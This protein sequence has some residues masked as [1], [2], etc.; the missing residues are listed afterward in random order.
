MP[1]VVFATGLED[2]AAAGIED[3]DEILSASVDVVRLEV[4]VKIWATG[5]LSQGG[6]MVRTT[7][8]QFP[9][10]ALPH[11]S[12]V[13]CMRPCSPLPPTVLGLQVL[14]WR[15]IAARMMGGTVYEHLKVGFVHRI[16][17]SE[18]ERTSVLCAVLFE[19]PNVWLAGT[20]GAALGNGIVEAH[21]NEIRHGD[22]GRG[23]SGPIDTTVH[24]VNGSVRASSCSD[25]R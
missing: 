13:S 20:E 11:L 4:S 17:E 8:W 23:P 9:P 24:P 2:V 3:R 14:S 12:T 18:M 10:G 15:A 7:S 21:N 16:T 6:Q 5:T 1:A 22:V 25:I 19:C